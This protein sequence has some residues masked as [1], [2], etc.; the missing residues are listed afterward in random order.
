MRLT[1]QAL[2]S[3]TVPKKI[4]WLRREAELVA[5]AAAGL[6]P[7]QA[8]CSHCCNIGT[9]VAEPE[10]IAIG[11]AIGRTPANVPAERV[12]RALASMQGDDGMKQAEAVRELVN[13][14]FYG[15]P[16]TFLVEGRC[17]IYQHRPMSCRYLVNFDTD[18]LLCR[19]VPEEPSRR[20]T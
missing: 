12:T 15:V 16:C 3:E 13:S 11:K 1:R 10:A 4:L 9:L 5:T 14:E 2:N 19:L 6:T 8:G 18:A 20:A 7:C 17:S